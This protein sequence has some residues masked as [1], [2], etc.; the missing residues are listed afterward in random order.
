MC[1]FLLH[2]L[3]SQLGQGRLLKSI[4]CLVYHLLDLL[5][6]KRAIEND[7]QYFL[8]YHLLQKVL[9]TIKEEEKDPA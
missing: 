9:S 7:N 5:V 3:A 2:K 4:Q 1:L 8:D 6:K